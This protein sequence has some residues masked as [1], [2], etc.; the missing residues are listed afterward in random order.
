MNAKPKIL[1]FGWE[2]PPF[3]SG[4]LGVACLGIT[5]ALSQRGFEV[6]F[7][8]P[9]KLN[10]QTPWAKMVFADAVV[11]ESVSTIV[12]NTPIQAYATSESYSSESRNGGGGVYANDLFSEVRRYAAT[13][14]AIARQETCDVIYAHDWLSFGAGVEAK[15]ATGKPLIVHVHATEFDRSGGSAHV[16]SHVY[17]EEKRGMEEADCVIAVS[18]LTKKIITDRYG[19][20]P[21]KVQIVYNGIDE[22]TMPQGNDLRRMRSLKQKGYKIVLF[23]GRITLQKGP[24]YFLRA[25]KRVVECDPKVMFVVSGAGDMEEG[26]IRLSAELGISQNV[27]F[28]G[29]LT[30]SDRHEMY[31]AADLFVMPSVSEPFGIAPLE[32]MRLGT[33][34]LISKQSGVSEVVQ[35]ALK[36]DFWDIDAMAERILSI[37]SYPSLSVALSKNAKQEA[38]GLTWAEAAIKIEHVVESLVQRHARR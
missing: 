17:T 6:L 35:H 16:N 36:V 14:A 24:D 21:D 30:G 11:G 12:V 3:H 15:H 1:M 22:A 32:S 26:I 2:F 34:V 13:G 31:T 10:I 20:S 5:R 29:F 27:I 18:E 28:T 4:G 7:V 8:V 37:V 9:K 23:L 25:A 19:I 38:K 33:P